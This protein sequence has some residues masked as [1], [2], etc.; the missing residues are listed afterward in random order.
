MQFEARHGS[1]EAKHLRTDRLELTYIANLIAAFLLLLTPVWFSIRYLDLSAI[2][3][4]TIVF[5][6]NLPVQLMKLFFGP[7]TLIEGGLF[8]EAYQF[9]VLMENVNILAQTAG[10]VFFYRL[11]ASARIEKVLPFQRIPLDRKDLKRGE[12]LFLAVFLLVFYVM[13]SAEFGLVNWLVNPRTGYQLYR[14]GQGHWYAIAISALA[15]AMV[16]ACLSN[17]TPSNLL[18]VGFVYLALGY[19]L[20]SKGLLL[21]IFL[22]VLVF[23]WFIRWRHLMKLLVVGSIAIFL[24][25]TFNLYLALSD[26]FELQ[27]VVSYFD[28]YKNAADYYRDYLS[29]QLGLF[30]GDIAISSLWAYVPRTIWPDKPMVYGILLVNDIFFPGQAELTNTPA[31]GGAVE[32]FADFGVVGVLVYGFFSMQSIS[33]AALSYLIYRRPGVDISRVTL[34]TVLLMIIQFSP[35]FGTFFPGILYAILLVL[36]VLGIKLTRRRR[37]RKLNITTIHFKEPYPPI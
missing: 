13:A 15:V 34:L 3:P 30:Y 35:S 18:R 24:L 22:T 27:S 2:N 8:D 32:Q 23:F 37:L 33:T 25:M 21:N 5:A 16:L 7:M 36:V 4:L 31:F 12:W 14:V 10:M 26:G 28:Y 1:R 19:L 6:V 17:P 20:G 11:F 29:G 9:A